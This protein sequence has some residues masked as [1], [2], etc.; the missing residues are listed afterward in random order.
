M[1]AR[2]VAVTASVMAVM[3]MALI[4]ESSLKLYD[5]AVA[6]VLTVEQILL[7]WLFML[8]MVF[9]H[10]TPEMVSIAVAFQYFQWSENNEL[11]TLR[12]TGL[13]NRRIALPGVVVAVLAALFCGL[14]ST[15][16]VPMAAAGITDIR[17]AAATQLPGGIL[18]LLQAGHQQQ[19]AP[20]VSVGF[21]RS[22]RDA[23][24]LERIIVLDRRKPDAPTSTWAERGRLVQ[25]ENGPMLLLEGGAHLTRNAGEEMRV[26]FDRLLV[27]L[28]APPGELPARGR[29]YFEESV[30]Q[31]LDPPAV[32]RDDP[33]QTLEWQVEGHHRLISPLLCI[34]NVLLVLGLLIANRQERHGGKIRLALAIISGFL[35]S[36]IPDTVFAIAARHAALL[37][38][39][40]LLPLV[41]GLL[42]ALL[43]LAG[44]RPS[45][46]LV[47]GWRRIVPV[48]A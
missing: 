47:R 27:P 28:G 37:P 38:G 48:R 2:L 20:G 43:M 21:E 26:E 19:I 5:L 15:W 24:G 9:Y 17:V 33:Q 35:V 16:L 3:G 11:L 22:D 18:D 45:P 40:Y 8:P 32:V 14:M 7:S 39:L 41:P 10:A 1:L 36:L 42:G 25:T 23:G 13:S 12:N 46:R 4:L 44:D 34:G 6:G 31:L 29:G 30:P